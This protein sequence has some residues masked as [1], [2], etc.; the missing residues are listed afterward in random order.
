MAAQSN[1]TFISYA[2]YPTLSRHDHMREEERSRQ[3]QRVLSLS[4]ILR[5]Y[6][7]DTV[8]DQY[9]EDD[10]PDSWPMWMEENIR[11]CKWVLMVCT[12][13]YYHHITGKS[14]ESNAEDGRGSR[15]EGKTIYGL[16]T[17]E[18]QARKF[19]P[20]FLD[21]KD[22]NWLPASLKGGHYYDLKLPDIV[23]KKTMLENE[24]FRKLYAR[25]TG[26]N[27]TPKPPVGGIVHL[28]SK[29]SA[30]SVAASDKSSQ[31]LTVG[32]RQLDHPSD[33]KVLLSVGVNKLSK[34]FNPGI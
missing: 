1:C 32:H 4:N 8:L 14:A 17:D 29:K 3:R 25:L 11:H 26:Q 30:H 16:L 2:H 33:E 18:S 7:V 21:K 22:L 23:P 15:F 5:S 6:G 12:E 19:I 27:R 24:E 34:L 20:V 10:P 31:C 9:H 13:S 28:P